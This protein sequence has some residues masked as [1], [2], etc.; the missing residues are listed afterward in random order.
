M[1][2][3]PTATIDLGLL[4]FFAQEDIKYVQKVELTISNPDN[5]TTELL[6]TKT[7]Q[8][9]SVEVELVLS[10]CCFRAKVTP[11]ETYWDEFIMTFFQD[12]SPFVSINGLNYSYKNDSAYNWCEGF[13]AI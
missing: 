2:L 10:H 11:D 6:S 5:E 4:M 1:H 7:M 12:D 13:G 8:N 9:A 3:K